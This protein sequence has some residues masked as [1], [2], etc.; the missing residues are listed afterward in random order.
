MFKMEQC[1]SNNGLDW[2]F[3]GNRCCETDGFWEAEDRG[4]NHE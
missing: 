2:I 3:M 4:G 1:S